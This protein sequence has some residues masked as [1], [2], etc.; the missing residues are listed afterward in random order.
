M[1]EAKA[2]LRVREVARHELMP[3]QRRDERAD[4]HRSVAC[5]EGGQ[6][7]Q[8][9]LLSDDRCNPERTTDVGGK[10]IDAACDQTV[11]RRRRR[12][13]PGVLWPDAPPPVVEKEPSAVTQAAQYFAYEKGIAM[14]LILHEGYHGL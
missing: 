7:R 5:D 11:Q 13:D 10:S 1:C 3:R 9:D 6:N 8:I 2:A 4:S 12:D 14:R